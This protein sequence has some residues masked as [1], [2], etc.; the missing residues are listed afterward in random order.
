[1]ETWKQLEDLY[2]HLQ[3]FNYRMNW[4]VLFF[5]CCPCFHPDLLARHH[6]EVGDQQYQDVGVSCRDNNG[7]CTA[8]N[9]MKNNSCVCFF[10]FSFQAVRVKGWV[11]SFDPLIIAEATCS[12]YGLVGWC[13]QNQL[14]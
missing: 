3:L 13:S 4:D 6:V 8:S 12:N 7:R 14:L 1:M 9:A 2:F 5:L 10:M 11:R